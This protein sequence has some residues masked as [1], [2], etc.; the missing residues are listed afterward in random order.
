MK[1]IL[2]VCSM[3]FV[4]CSSVAPLLE[5]ETEI[6]VEEVAELAIDDIVNSSKKTND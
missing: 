5:K 6:V 1:K 4:S 3:F 2:F